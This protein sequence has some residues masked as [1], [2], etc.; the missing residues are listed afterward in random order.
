MTSDVDLLRQFISDPNRIV[1][2]TDDLLLERIEHYEGDIEAAAAEIWLVKAATV[3][4]WYSASVD[5][6][7]FSREQ[8]FE[9]CIEMAKQWQDRAAHEIESILMQVTPVVEASEFS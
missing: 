4:D 2:S 5:G 9:H 8:V 7:F 6:R 1:F 3:S